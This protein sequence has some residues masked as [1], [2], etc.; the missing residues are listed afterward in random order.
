MGV[1]SELV[2]SKKDTDLRI[3]GFVRRSHIDPM[4]NPSNQN[5]YLR[6]WRSLVARVLGRSQSDG[7]QEV[8]IIAS[9]AAVTL[10]FV[11]FV[12]LP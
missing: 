9:L 12:F 1:P 11:V 10:M 6:Q 3:I 8:L 5:K 2:V 7:D 4:P